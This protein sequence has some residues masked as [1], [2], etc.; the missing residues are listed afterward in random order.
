MPTLNPVPAPDLPAV[1]RRIRV[2]SNFEELVAT[3]MVDGVNALCWR[4]QLPGDFAEVAELLGPTEGITP[5]DETGLRRL[6]LSDAGRIACEVMLKDRDILRA[7]DL[8][9]ELNVIHC[10][11]RDEREGPFPTDVYSWH[12]DSATVPADTWLCTY[13]GAPSEGLRNE[14]ARRRVDVPEIRAELL[15]LYGGGDDEGFAE[16]LS[17]NFYDLHYLAKPGAQPYSF[18]LQHLWRVATDYPGNPVPPCIHRA[19]ETRAA[20]HPRLLL[21]S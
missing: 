10:T 5:I 20:D 18:G 2:V 12:V 14:D 11:V 8:L 1:Y 19:P 13:T 3:P 4:R 16:F 17:E 7:V 6:S 15:A 9:P 21:I